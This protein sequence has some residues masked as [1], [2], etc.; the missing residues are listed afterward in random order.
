MLQ[1]SETFYMHRDVPF[2]LDHFPPRVTTPLRYERTGWIIASNIL[3][4]VYT[5]VP[6][7][8]GLSEVQKNSFPLAA[9]C[10]AASLA[11]SHGGCKSKAK[12]QV[13]VHYL[14]NVTTDKSSLTSSQEPTFFN[15][16][17]LLLS[18]LTV[19]PKSRHT[20]CKQSSWV[21]SPVGEHDKSARPSAKS[22]MNN[23]INLGSSWTPCLPFS[24]T[25]VANSFTMTEKRVGLKTHPCLSPRGHSNM[26]VNSLLILTQERIF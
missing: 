23:S 16:I 20:L 11:F 10:F 9:N 2:L 24:D 21:C 17:T 1:R 6:T 3:K 14:E 8:C 15:T 26:S 12:V 22:S 5:F 13:S 4:N 19:R 18:V 7:G 25:S